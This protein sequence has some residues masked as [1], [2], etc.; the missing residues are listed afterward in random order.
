MNPRAY[1]ESNFIGFFEVLEWVRQHKE[2]PLIY[3]SSSSVYG[4]TSEAPFKEDDKADMPESFYAASK[5]SNELMAISYNKT[6][7]IKARGL[8]F[9]TVYGPYGRPDMAYFSFTDA[10]VNKKPLK[11]FHQ[12]QALRDFTY[13]D[14]IVDG[15]I[16]AI[17]HDSDCTVFNLGHNHPYT[18]L[19]LISCIEDYFGQKAI[20]DF[21]E[22]PKG[23]VNVTYGSVEGSH[24]RV[25][26]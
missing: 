10:I 5:R 12:G 4:N 23:V 20:L 24:D 8:R 9:F 11:V 16:A 3:A 2:V 21:V 17:F 6:F 7:G 14:D 25:G 15:I 26:V 19:E 1:L 18:T 13:I 22:G